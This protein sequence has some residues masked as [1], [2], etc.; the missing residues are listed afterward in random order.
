MPDLRYETADKLSPHRDL[1]LA[2]RAWRGSGAFAN[3]QLGA[4]ANGFD[5]LTAKE[6]T[7]EFGG[8]GAKPEFGLADG[9]EGHSKMFANQ[10]V[11][12]A[13]E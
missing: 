5:F 9:G 2:R 3:G 6:F 7:H 1:N 10:H 8:G 11:P 4:E 13:D 12:E